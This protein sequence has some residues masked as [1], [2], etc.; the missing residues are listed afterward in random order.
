MSTTD[1]AP[2]ARQET[3]PTFLS[4]LR[5]ND[6]HPRI[7]RALGDAQT[8]HSLVMSL[9]P[10]IPAQDAR[11]A[12]SVLYRVDEDGAA[13]GQPAT[14]ARPGRILIVQSA[15]APDRDGSAW[16][17]GMLRDDESSPDAGIETR[18][19]EAAF[20]RITDGQRLGFRLRANPTKRLS[21]S[22]PQDPDRPG[23]DPLLARHQ[24]PRANGKEPTGPRV[25]LLREP[26]QIDWLV[27]QGERHGF[28]LLPVR[29][30]TTMANEDAA[31]PYAVQVASVTAR[32]LRRQTDRL[33]HLAVT[34]DGE[35]TVT[36]PDRFRAALRDGIGPAKAYGF[37]LLSV[38]PPR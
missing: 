14:T 38:R 13:S 32:G 22:R 9:F 16:S 15:I 37:G 36:D 20:A 25:A 24:Q 5:L 26:E 17:P 3:A 12:I 6:G 28:A 29:G 23:P 33:T 27:R 8:L 34:F 1:I 31:P 11:A 2:G 30:R 10:D 35:L 7:Q 19:A 18:V 21:L 4:R